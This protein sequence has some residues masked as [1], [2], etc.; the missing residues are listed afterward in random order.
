[1]T[2]SEIKQIEDKKVFRTGFEDLLLRKFFYV[3]AFEIYGGVGGLYDF[4][5][6]GCA[7]RSNI[8]EQWRRHFILKENMLEVSCSNLTPYPVLKTSGHVDKFTDFLVKDTVNGECYRADKLVEE[9]LE[10]LLESKKN[11][12][13]EEKRAEMLAA[14]SDAGACSADQLQRYIETYKV[15]APGT[16]NTLSAPYPFN[17]MFETQI[18]PTGKVLGY[19][20][21]ETAQGM[22]VNFKR[23]LE[24]N[25]GRM[26]F[27]AAQ[28]GTAFRNEIAPRSGLLRVREFPLAEIEHF[29]NP[30]DKSHTKFHTV[31]N[32]T[33]SLLDRASQNGEDIPK[34]LTAGEAVAQGVIGNETLAYFMCRTSMFLIDCGIKPEKLRFRQHK[35]TEMAHYSSDCWDAEVLTTYGWIECVGHA[36]RSAYD[37]SVHSVKTK[38]DLMAQEVYDP[39]RMEEEVAV[40]INAGKFGPAFGANQQKYAEHLR[41]LTKPDALKLQ[42]ELKGGSSKVTLCTGESFELKADMVA[43]EIKQKKVSVYKYL[44]GVIEPAFGIGRIMYAVLEHSYCVRVKAGEEQGIL[45]LAPLIAPVKCA[46]LPLA[47]SPESSALVRALEQGFVKLGMATKVDTSGASIGRKYARADEIGV[48][49]G[50]TIDF[51]S[52]P[53]NDCTVRDRDS[54]NQI[55][56]PVAEAPAI[57]HALCNGKSTWAATYAKY[58]HFTGPAEDPAP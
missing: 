3:P 52:V 24:F 45:Q 6:P 40:K 51:E 47:S 18:G 39:P 27:A 33:L 46:I 53:N 29:L 19:M 1:M 15:V 38:Q 9:H 16:G 28:M 37:L 23:L 12:P 25:G 35:A 11:P 44:P 42:A 22:F 5:P 34:K 17:L 13:S 43:I 2:T 49:F 14:R 50:I 4:G 57:V 30:R 41:N 36:D 7:V 8:L 31:A 20:R 54:L 26:P 55:R 48:P 32:Y 56:V 10:S 58:P 21:P